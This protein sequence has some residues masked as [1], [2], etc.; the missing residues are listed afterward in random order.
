M[1]VYVKYEVSFHGLQFETKQEETDFREKLRD[2]LVELH[3]NF[4]F[5]RGIDNDIEIEP[6]EQAGK[7]I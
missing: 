2:V 4:G 5:D 3:T 6:I 1:I 7:A